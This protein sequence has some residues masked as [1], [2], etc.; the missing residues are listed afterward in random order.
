MD[1]VDPW[2]NCIRCTDLKCNE[3]DK[4]TKYHC[5]ALTRSP[6]LHTTNIYKDKIQRQTLLLFGVR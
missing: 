5:R 1:S 2:I 6:L 3:K 4:Q